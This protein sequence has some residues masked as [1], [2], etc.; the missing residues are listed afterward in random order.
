MRRNPDQV[1]IRTIVGVAVVLVLLISFVVQTQRK[2]QQEQ[3][4]QAPAPAPGQE[5]G[6]GPAPAPTAPADSSVH[7]TMGNPSGATD[8]PANAD[9]YLMRKPYFALAYNNSKGTPNWVSWT[10]TASDLGAA[11]RVEFYPDTTLPQAFRHVY[12]RDYSN[13]GFDRGHLCP[14]SDRA[15]TPEASRATFVMTNMVPQAPHLNQ[16]AWADMEDYCR[17]LVRRR[18]ASLHIVAGPVG[19]GGEGAKGPADA[20]GNGRVTVPAKCWKVVLVVENGTGSADDL[21]RVNSSSRV[22]AVVMPNDQSVGH[23]WARFRTSVAEVEALTGYTFFDR[24]PADI[25]RPLKTQVD[26]EAVRP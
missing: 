16:Q 7:L 2:R 24:V 10:L 4:Q 22:I 1:T 25:I 19:Q 15:A 8:D 14:H 6:P 21:G 11:P 9:N 3:P 23:G 18:P 20:V 17:V 5:P 12:P 13:G 26:T